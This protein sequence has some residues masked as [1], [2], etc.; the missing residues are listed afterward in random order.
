MNRI[1][2]KP[3]DTVSF[4][5]SSG[6]GGVGK[7]SMAV[8]MA[9]L[10]SK[11]GRRTL[12]IDGD[13]GLANVDVQLGVSVHRTIRDVLDG[14]EDPLE[15]VVYPREGLGVL[16]AS[17]GVPHMVTLSP[18]EQSEL[19]G[20]L[21]S[22]FDHFDTVIVDTAAG[23]GPSV[24]WFNAFVDHSIV[25]ATPDPTSLTDAYAL[26]KVLYNHHARQQFYIMLNSVRDD[27]E[28]AAVYENL[29]GVTRRFLEVNTRFLGA[30]PTDPAVSRGLRSR[31]PFVSQS[32]GAPSVQ[33]LQKVVE[34]LMEL[35][36][37]AR[38]A[39]P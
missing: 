38:R 7:T 6:K 5:I 25:V 28:A 33:A 26:V 27:E 34:R 20:A 9:V 19:A 35:K 31:K 10:F 24:Q 29:A 39:A 17:S 16:P 32:P 36:T 11:A 3:S 22:M 18:E 23:I 21:D 14:G 15:A 30:V 13:L 1:T 37:P 12:L 4:A 8:S 2:G